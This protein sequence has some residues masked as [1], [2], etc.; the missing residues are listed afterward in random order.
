VGWIL[1]GLGG[2]AGRVKGGENGEAGGKGEGEDMY[3]ELERARE[4]L[5]VERLLGEV[6]RLGG[7]GDGNGGMDE[8]RQLGYGWVDEIPVVRKWM[9][10]L[11]ERGVRA[12]VDLKYEREVERHAVA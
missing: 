3:G 2:L 10:V 8:E 5:R 6:E 11:E 9:R 1:G 4:E 7:G 12:G